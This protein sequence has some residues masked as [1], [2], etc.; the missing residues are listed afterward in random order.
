M[1]RR[2]AEPADDLPEELSL[3]GFLRQL[4]TFRVHAGS[5]AQR[6]ATLWRFARLFTSELRDVYG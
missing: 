6:A 2:R 4:T 5:P 1:A 3:P